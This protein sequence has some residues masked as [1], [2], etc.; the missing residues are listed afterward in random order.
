[1]SKKP[2]SPVDSN[3]ARQEWG[4]PPLLV[5]WLKENFGLSWDVCA[6][7]GNAVFGPQRCYTPKMDGLSR[8]W[9]NGWFCN[10]PW[11]NI[12]PWVYEA[13]GAH[14]QCRSG[15]MLVPARTD[16]L[17]FANATRSARV[18]WITGRLAYIPAPGVEESQSS[19]L[20]M[21]LF[22]GYEVELRELHLLKHP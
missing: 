8:P 2:I 14:A 22:F 21:L 20:S 9:P 3:P 17:W 18:V 12:S 6:T 4:T 1:M 16:R 15:I 19:V 13:M 10:P 7:E 5:K 11:K